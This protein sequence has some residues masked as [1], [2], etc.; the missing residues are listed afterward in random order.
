MKILCLGH[1]AYDITLEAENYPKENSKSE[2][3]YV[4]ESGGG[5][6]A[7]CA[8]LLSK[9]QEETYVCG[10]IGYDTYGEKIKKEFNDFK[11]NTDYLEI[12]YENKTSLSY[13]ILNSLNAS[14][15]ILRKKNQL[16]PLK[17][18]EFGVTEFNVIL[19][20]GYYYSSALKALKSQAKAISILDAGKNSKEVLDLCPKVKFI[21][22]SKEF[23][24]EIT[25]IKPDK[26]DVNK[27]ASMFLEMKKR[28]PAQE[29]IITLEDEGAVYAYENH[30]KILP[31]LKVVAKDSTGAGD[32]FH[33]AF[34]Y[35][36]A[37]TKDVE[38]AVKF[39]NVTAGLSVQKIGVKN[40]LPT[41]DEVNRY[42]EQL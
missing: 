7:N 30:I 12:D 26:G 5:S 10:V 31:A 42:Y 24:E 16:I 20:D 34:A 19:L 39:A 38:K 27:I 3:T 2:L 9:W 8:C 14:R 35:Q 36:Y 28:Y 11:V 23:A 29:I 40:S 17:K 21:I 15:T 6:I 25:G 33:G 13:I 37:K 22:S 18:A 4:Y 32:I 1:I 41:L